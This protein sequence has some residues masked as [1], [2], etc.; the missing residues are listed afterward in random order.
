MAKCCSSIK[1]LISNDMQKYRAE[2]LRTM[3]IPSIGLNDTKETSI[4]RII[5]DIIDLQNVK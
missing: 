1:K 4:P 5:F 3:G 2:E